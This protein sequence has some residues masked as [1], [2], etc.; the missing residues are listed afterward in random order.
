MSVLP[1]FLVRMDRTALRAVVVTLGLFALVFTILLLGKSGMLG[2]FEDTKASITALAGGPWGLPALILMF[3]IAAFVGIPQFGLIAAAVVAFGPWLGFGYAWIAT[4]VSG[5]LTFWL[6]RLAGEATMRRYAGDTANRLAA[7][8]GRNAFLASALVRNVPTGPFI[9]VNMAFGVSRARFIHYWA[10][11]AI[12]VLPKIA[13]VA[14]AGQSVMAALDGRAWIA[15]L[16]AGAGGGVWIALMLY[17]RARV[18]AGRKT[19]SDFDPSPVDISADTGNF[20]GH[21]KDLAPSP[22]P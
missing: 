6:G 20:R 12:G 16:A 13:L 8:I 18:R 7:F 19:V 9:V 2:T 4:M 21:A 17:A 5:A 10:G 22:P 15:L 14:F 1:E 11:M 3:C